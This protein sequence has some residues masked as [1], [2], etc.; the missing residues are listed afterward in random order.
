MNAARGFYA[1]ASR[2]A[3]C[4]HCRHPQLL[5]NLYKFGP[6]ETLGLE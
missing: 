1:P 5:R 6:L 2:R 3:G 4:I